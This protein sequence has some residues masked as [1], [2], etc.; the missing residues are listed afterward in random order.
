MIWLGTNRNCC[1]INL[2]QHAKFRH[3]LSKEHTDTVHI[4]STQFLLLKL[5]FVFWRYN[6]DADDN[7]I[8]TNNTGIPI[9]CVFS[10]KNTTKFISQ[11]LEAIPLT[12]GVS[13]LTKVYG[14]TFFSV[15]TRFYFRRKITDYFAVICLFG[16]C[17]Q[18]ELNSR[19]Q[20][21]SSKVS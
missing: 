21:E 14:F 20:D 6:T 9:E 1:Y 10:Q 16:A 3:K 7:G 12:C 11:T 8:T 2:L 13:K 5:I 18:Y 19:R 15:W 4:T 17:K